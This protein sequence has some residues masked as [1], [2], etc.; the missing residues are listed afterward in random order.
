MRQVAR[1]VPENAV[2]AIKKMVWAP[3]IFAH[4]IYKDPFSRR[5]LSEIHLN[6][7]TEQIYEEGESIRP[8]VPPK[9]ALSSVLEQL[10]DEFHH[11]RL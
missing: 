8:S 2:S 9:K 3:Q 11:L 5:P 6:D 7:I 4:A 1:S 10:L